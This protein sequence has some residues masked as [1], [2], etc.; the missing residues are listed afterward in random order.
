LARTPGVAAT[1]TALVI[2]A[3]GRESV[4]RLS[5]DCAADALADARAIAA[6]TAAKTTLT[7]MRTISHL[8][9]D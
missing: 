5:H 4:A 8:R 2:V 6:K 7:R 9:D 3:F 1:V